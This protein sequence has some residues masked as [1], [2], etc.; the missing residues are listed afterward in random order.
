[1]KVLYFIKEIQFNNIQVFQLEGLSKG[2]R[3]LSDFFSV[4]NYGQT[5]FCLNLGIELT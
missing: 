2:S 4:R 5:I 3:H 1:M